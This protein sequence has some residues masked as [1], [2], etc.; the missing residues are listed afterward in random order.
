MILRYFVQRLVK[1]FFMLILGA[2][3][4]IVATLYI[5]ITQP[6]RLEEAKRIAARVG[7]GAQM[8]SQSSPARSPQAGRSADTAQVRLLDF[9]ADWCAPCKTQ[10]PIVNKLA[11]A[12]SGRV[13]V[14][15]I[16]IDKSPD[17]A[18]RYEIQG[19]PTLII[20]RNGRIAKRLMGLQEEAT[21]AAALDDALRM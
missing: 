20:E 5:V 10:D 3:I 8:Y 21:L 1:T 6:D 13:V 2:A 16:D 18:S 11:S 9:G 4:G 14:T 15:K 17:L 12:Y 7:I 19:V